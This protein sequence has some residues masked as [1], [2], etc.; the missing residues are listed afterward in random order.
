MIQDVKL[1]FSVVLPATSWC[2]PARSPVWDISK[3][4]LTPTERGLPA[5]KSKDNIFFKTLENHFSFLFLSKHLQDYLLNTEDI[6]CIQM[7]KV[8]F[9]SVKDLKT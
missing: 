5:W 3:S 6:K 1:L 4:V 2:H 8:F 9:K 7:Y